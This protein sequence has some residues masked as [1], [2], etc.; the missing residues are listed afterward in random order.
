MRSTAS[1]ERLAKRVR[2]RLGCEEG[3]VDLHQLCER[4]DLTF[5]ARTLPDGTSG[6]LVRRPEGNVLVVDQ[7]EPVQRQRFTAAHEI[8]HLLLHK[9]AEIF[10]D[11]RDKRSQSGRDPKEIE[12]NRFAAALLMPEHLLRRDAESSTALDDDELIQELARRYE[13]SKTAM[14]IRLSSLGLIGW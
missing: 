9:D 4:L 2:A 14:S 13:V 1:I 10:V 7:T 11:Y 12:A 5:V 6:M 3:A 8:G